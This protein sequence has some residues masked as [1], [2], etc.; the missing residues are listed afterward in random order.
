MAA[1]K[2]APKRKATKKSKP[3][4]KRLR[5]KKV[6]ERLSVATLLAQS[7]SLHE[8]GKQATSSINGRRVVARA[9]DLGKMREAR[10]FRVQADAQDPGHIDPAWADEQR[11]TPMGTDTHKALM[12][13]YRE[14]LG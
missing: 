1:K 6:E 13:F 4:T 7:M 5:A 10:D 9:M 2:K 14:K 3:K 12:E 8:Q 11:L